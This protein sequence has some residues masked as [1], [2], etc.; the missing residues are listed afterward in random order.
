MDPFCRIPSRPRI[1]TA[2]SGATGPGKNIERKC[3]GIVLCQT[4][5]FPEPKCQSKVPAECDCEVCKKSAWKSEGLGRGRKEKSLS[6]GPDGAG[7]SRADAP[8]IR[9]DS[10]LRGG[11]RS[12]AAVSMARV[13]LA[14]NEFQGQG[15]AGMPPPPMPRLVLGGE[16]Q[17]PPVPRGKMLLRAVFAGAEGAESCKKRSGRMAGL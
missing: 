15:A 14:S 11:P 12:V 10:R 4:R 9:V 3:Y 6:R 7:S 17:P 13:C 1:C 5:F 2:E 16:I 8:P